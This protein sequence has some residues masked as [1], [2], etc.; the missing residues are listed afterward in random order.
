M[1]KAAMSKDLTAKIIAIILAVVV[2]AQVFND[3]NPIER[4]T[5]VLDVVPAMVEDGMMIVSTKPDKVTVTLEGR[6]RTLDELDE[7]KLKVEVDLSSVEPGSFSAN[8]HVDVP[9]GVKVVEINPGTVTFE[10]DVMSSAE[11]GVVVEVQGSPGEDYEKG[12]PM[13]S[14]GTV[15]VKGAKRFVD[16]VNHAC[17][18]VDITGATGEVTATAKLVA[19]DAVGSELSGIQ[20]EPAE[21]EVVVP[22]QK[23]P[24]AKIVPVQ[25]VV[26]GT[27]KDGY[28]VGPI[29]ANPQQVKIRGD[30]G[31]ID[32]INW[33]GTKPVDVSGKDGVFQS[34][35][36]L[37]LPAGVTCQTQQVV[38][39]I[40]IIEEIETRTLE[41]VI[42][43]LESPP[44]GYTWSIEPATV[45]V[46][47]TGRSDLVRKVQGENVTV[48]IDAQGRSEGTHDLVVAYKIQA[49]EGVTVDNLQ[50]DIKPPKV[51][52]TLTKR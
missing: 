36:A 47:L 20:I 14:V 37:S 21:I 29:V 44:V 41:D 43:Q 6:A 30:K 32:T 7:K 26:S 34:T 48:Y 1:I 39:K 24:P 52:L 33:I 51:K 8:P 42:V 2:W 4:R 12:I 18:R 13:P 50:V 3:K 27:P 38:V 31:V 10:L 45:S 5:L 25:V 11:V 35:V 9:Y 22:L 46:V 17:A 23:L 40:D 19:V 15:T 28:T 49:P 16:K